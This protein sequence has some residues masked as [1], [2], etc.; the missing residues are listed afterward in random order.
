MGDLAII[1]NKPKE[2]SPSSISCP[3]L[4]YTNYTVWTV[5]MKI[6]LK[7]HKVWKFIETES[8]ESEKNDMAIA[9]LFQSI[10]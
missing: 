6:L 9:L 1:V 2:A 3:M 10:P 8:A 5:K 4:N 7:V